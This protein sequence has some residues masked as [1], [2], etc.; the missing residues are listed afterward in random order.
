MKITV[1]FQ[2]VANRYMEDDHRATLHSLKIISQRNTGVTYRLS[3]ILHPELF[4]E[5]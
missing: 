1:A 2:T 5:L 3:R 4:S